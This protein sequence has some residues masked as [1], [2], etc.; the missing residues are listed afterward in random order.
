M[1]ALPSLGACLDSTTLH[2]SHGAAHPRHE[3]GMTDDRDGAPLDHCIEQIP[4]TFAIT[5][6]ATC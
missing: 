6:D 4:A 5:E 2:Q 3:R 1:R